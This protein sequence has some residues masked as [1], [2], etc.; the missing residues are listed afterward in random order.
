MKIG[1]ITFHAS[2]NYGSMLQA[3]ALHKVLSDMGHDVEIINF[4]SAEQKE[5][6]HHPIKLSSSEWSKVHMLMH[7]LLHCKEYLTQ[8]RKWNKYNAFLKKYLVHT[9]E[10]HTVDELRQYDFFYDYL[11]IGSDQIWNTRCRDFSEAFWCNFCSEKI[12]KVAYAPSMGRNP[13]SL[14]TDY[15]RRSLKHF[16]AVSVRE[17]RTKNVLINKDI[18]KEISLT[19]D[20]TFLLQPSDYSGFIGDRPLVKGKYIYFYD[21]F[22]R[23]QFLKIALLIGRDKG[24]RVVVDRTYP[25]SA[26][27]GFDNVI[28][29]T[30]VGPKEFLNL[31]KYSRLVVAHS[32]H[33]VIFSIIFKRDFY[34]LDGD[35]D[36][37]MQH[38]LNVL[39]LEKRAV[40]VEDHI[41]HERITIDYWDSV[42][43]KY[44]A[45]KKVSLD[46]IQNS[47]DAN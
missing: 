1:I 6:Y 10:F 5:M 30:A 37:R 7:Y 38:I 32:L 9:K 36:S 41:L 14:D 11:V 40:N 23:P 33:A 13:E 43:E 15:I 46:F 42:Y 16:Y 3:Y 8:V 31:V 24:L 47:I 4:R 27:K 22:V 28:F 34:A 45:L 21:P 44:A 12:K 29:H 25:E 26:Y 2:F 17:S 20:P 39:S 35:S 19:L 18:F